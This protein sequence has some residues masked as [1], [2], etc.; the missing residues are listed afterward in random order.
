MSFTDEN[1][2]RAPLLGGE[3]HQNMGK[4]DEAKT[5]NENGGYGGVKSSGVAIKELGDDSDTSSVEIKDGEDKRKV[6]LSTLFRYATAFDYFI[7]VIGG[8]AALAHGAGWPVLNLFFGDLIDEFI[9]F[10]TD[11]TTAIPILP[12]GVTYPPFDPMEEFDK[13]MRKYALTFTYVGIA[14]VFASYIQVSC[15]SLSCERQSHKLRKEFFR[16]ILHQEI[17]WFD[18]HQSGELTSRLADD[19][20]RVREGLGDKIAV[21]LQFLSQFATG[22]AIGFWKSWE[23]TLVI[24]SLTPLLAIAGGFMAFLITSFSKAEQEAYAK[25]GSVS[26]EVLACIR[27]VIAFGGEHKEIKRYEKELEGA[28]KIGIKKGVIT[29]FGLGLT[30]FIMFSAYA[31]AFWYGPKMV[32][33]GRLTGGEVMT[34]FFCIMIGSFSIGNMIPPLSTVATARGAAVMLFD[35]IDEEPVIDMRSEEGLKPNTITGNIDFEKVEF[36]YP[37]RPDVPVLKGISLS[38]K[39]GQTVA[40]VGSSGCGKSTTVNLLLRFYD[41]LGGRILIDGNEVRDL[42]LRWLRQHI[43]VVSQEPVLF[44]CSIETNISYGRDGVTKEEMVNAAKMANAHDFIMKLPKGYDTIVG[45]R[46]AQLSGGQKQRVA[47]ARALVSNPSILLLDEAT[48]ALD[49]ESEKVV[50]QALDRA[51]EGRTTIVIAHRLSTIQ[52]ADIIYALNDGKV[53]EFGTHAELMKADGTYKQLVTLQMIGMEEGEDDEDEEGDSKHQTDKLARQ[54]SRQKSRHMSTSSNQD[55]KKDETEEEEEEIPKAS[56]WEVLK[57]NAPEWYL[58]A[59]GCFFSAILGVTMPVFAILFSEIIKIFS[60]PSDEMTE[61]AV[62]WSCMFVALGGT[63]FV[64]YAVSITC[65]AISGE[66]LTMRLRSKAFST[67]LRQDVAYFDQPTHSTGA[68]ATRLSADASN[69]KGATGVRL[70]TLFQTAVTLAAAIVIGFVFGWKLALVVLACVPLLVAAGGLQLRL[71]QGTQKRDSELLEEAGKIAAEAIENVR[72]VASLTLED[73]M[74]QGYADMLQL[75]FVQGQINT[76]Y[77]AIAFGITQGMVFFLYAAAFR[78]GGYLVAQGEM[79]TDEV[80]KVVFGIAFAGISLGQASAFLPDYAKA[81]HSANIILNLFATKPLIDNY[82]KSGLRP[83]NLNGEISYDAINFKYPTRPDIEILKGLS[84]TIKPGQTVALVGESGCGKST[85]VSL[86]ER[87]YDPELGSVSVDGNSIKDL[88]VQWLRANMSVVS[89]EPILFACSIKENIQYSV[90]K[91]MDMADIERVAKM[92]NIHGFISG[93]PMGYDTLVG[94]KGAQLSGGQKQRV[95]IA[96]ALARNPRI[97]L[98]DE[99]TSA[100]D[101][102]SEKIVQEALDAAVEGRTSIV[103]AHRLSTVQNA[104]VIAVIRDGIVVES[105]SHQELLNKKGHYYTLTGGQRS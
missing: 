75:P 89:Q 12:P 52:N 50:Q 49:S 100:L 26:E 81:R 16:A 92:A 94:E 29:A 87:F 3:N 6:P 4:K 31:L 70:S 38:V 27:T 95:A 74:Y 54:L 62:F 13:Q 48:S 1:N 18:K 40:L 66:R 36:T 30:F 65:L 11:N 28:K 25:A 82:S 22:F 60:L 104:D 47:I 101:T 35:V 58:I 77:Y 67:I 8:L 105:G 2:E 76:Q 19:M 78:F 88:N 79:T 71:M 42:N 68:L 14:V 37:S 99:A 98:L 90:D 44:N 55:K 69:V 45:E 32:S 83:S 7:M 80:F 10:D 91:E 61:Q 56:Y 103:I 33:E 15:W 9:D 59:I 93:L 96:R 20:E 39:T 5:A 51:S 73:K 23:L 17:A 41:I 64:G 24:M 97:L 53:V 72:T 57:L 46:G 84:L 85:L 43:G 102:E 63:M 86:L 21:C 34:V